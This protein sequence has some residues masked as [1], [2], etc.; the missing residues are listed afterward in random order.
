MPRSLFLK[1]VKG[2]RHA[3]WI[4]SISVIATEIILQVSDPLGLQFYSDAKEYFTTKI[5]HTEF[6]YYINRPGAE[7][8]FGGVPVSTNSEGFRD[9]EFSIEKPPETIR[10]LCMGD[11]IVFG[12]GAPQDSLFP[13]ELE[14]IAREEG[15]P[16]EVV[17]AAACSWNTRME[18]DFFRHKGK[19]YNPDILLL[20][21]VGN[22]L[23]ALDNAS[24][25]RSDFFRD[26]ILSRA[27]LRRS[28]LVC[29]FLHFRNK[30]LAGPKFIEQYE[31]DSKIFDE[32]ILAVGE[33]VSLCKALNVRPLV[34]L[35]VTGDG[36]SAFDQMYR[37][38]YTD[39]LKKHGVAAGVCQVFFS[40]RSL[41]VSSIDSHPTALGHRLI[42]QTMYPELR[43]M[44]VELTQE[45]E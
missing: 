28:S 41:R 2:L 3:A 39:E 37:G 14:K 31:R 45:G 18:F 33:M 43:S 23:V 21:V 36:S 19:L 8:V 5:R 24:S 1:I 32:N 35:G 10:V 34:F 42:A 11:S 12:W 27:G 20:L 30:F 13:V 9:D 17:T 38:L 7:Y 40:D 6:G 25:R 26:M 22:D 44:L 15:F 29:A 4:L 16:C